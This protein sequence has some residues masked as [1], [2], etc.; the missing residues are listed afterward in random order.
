MR[1]LRS[2]SLSIAISLVL[3]LTACMTGTKKGESIQRVDGLITHVERVHVEAVVSKEKSRAAL[4]VLS[5][6]CSPDFSGD[7]GATYAQLV[8]AIEQSE[9]Q[10]HTL[11]GNIGP[12]NM[13]ADELFE[14]WTLDLEAFGNS[15]MRQRSQ[16]RLEETRQRYQTLLGAAKAARIV[17][18]SFNADLRDCAI[19]IG[20]DFNAEAVAAIV[21]DVDALHERANELDAQFDAC[22]EAAR[23]YSEAA[24]LHGQVEVAAT[25]EAPVEE[26]PVESPAVE[27]EPAKRRNPYLKQRPGTTTPKTETNVDAGDTNQSNGTPR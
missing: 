23:A 8:T 5:Q 25:A 15:R 22:A 24:A 7:A 27:P 12:M 10:A 9:E 2:S 26:T 1:H 3:T 14:R 6:L 19:F 18:E 11:A 21:E 17:Y 13:A 4:E 16:L 20:N